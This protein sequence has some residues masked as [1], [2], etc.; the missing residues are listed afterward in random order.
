[1]IP[2]NQAADLAISKAG[3][4]EELA[5][6]KMRSNRAALKRAINDPR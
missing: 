4:V 3:R 1:M 6:V 2:G 5:Q